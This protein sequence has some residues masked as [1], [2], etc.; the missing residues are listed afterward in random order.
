M[1]RFMV[2]CVSWCQG[3][4]RSRLEPMEHENGQVKVDKRGHDMKGNGTGIDAYDVEYENLRR[5]GVGPNFGNE[6]AEQ[7]NKLMS[8]DSHLDA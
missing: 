5:S 8:T 1:L 3:M 7:P 2:M 6:T 4:S